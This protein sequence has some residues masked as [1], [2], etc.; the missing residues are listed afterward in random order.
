MHNEVDKGFGPIDML[1]FTSYNLSNI[2]KILLSKIFD[3]KVAIKLAIK[4]FNI[5]LEENILNFMLF[6]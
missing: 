4:E 1:V 3:M 2:Q 6:S 5:C